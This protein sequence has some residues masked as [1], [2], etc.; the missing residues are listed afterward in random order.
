MQAALSRL[1]L[2]GDAWLCIE[3]A[4]QQQQQHNKQQA[5]SSSRVVCEATAR[6]IVQVRVLLVC[7]VS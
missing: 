1:G 5:D 3:P 2:D 7:W 6:A 4:E